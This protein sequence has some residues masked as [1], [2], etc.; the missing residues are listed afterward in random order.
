ME[1]Q[2]LTIG[3]HRQLSMSYRRGL[4][5]GAKA[6]HIMAVLVC[7]FF[8][9]ATCGPCSMNGM[10]KPVEFDACGSYRDGHNVGFQDVFVG[11][12][13]LRY[14][15]KNPL[16]HLSVENV[17][18]NLNL[19]CFPSTLP[20]F[21]FE[22]ES[23]ILEVNGVQ[24]DD[25]L[26]VGSSQAKNNISWSSD[27]G[28]FRQSS[29]R[30]LSCSLDSQEGIH[31]IS[32][33]QTHGP[34]PNDVSSCRGTL[35]N[36]KIP[37]FNLNEN[38]RRIK[39]GFL[40]GSLSPHVEITPHLLDWGQQ[41]LYFPLLAFLT[42][43]NTHSDNILNLYEPFSTD[44][45][46]Y[47]CNFSEVLLGPGEVAS[48][49]FVFLPT[50]LGL[51]SAHLILQT[52]SGG[53]LIQARGFGTESPY[54]IQ[55][56]VDPEV[57]SNGRWN[58]N[59]SLFNPFDETLY[60]EEVTAWI[61]VSLGGTSHLTKAIC[62][63]ENSQGPNQ[64]IL[65]SVK[66]WLDVKNG[67]IGTSQLAMKPHRNWEIGPHSTQ[68][69]MEIDFSYNSEGKIFGVLCMQLQKSSQDTVIVP[70]EAELEA[71]PAYGD[72]ASSVS[73]SI[74]VL[75][76]CDGS[77]T[78]VATL[79]LKNS[80]SYLLNV[81]KIIVDGESTKLFQIKYME[82]LI[83][84]P[85]TV[86]QVAVVTYAPLPEIPNTYLNCELIILT[87]DSS[88]PQFE[89]PCRDIVNICPRNQFDSYIGYD[90]HSERIEHGNARTRS[91]GSSVKSA[92]QI[93]A[94]ETAEAD[95]L[96][97]GN[98][99]SQGTASRMTVLDDLEVLF[100]T[101]Q[102]GTHHSKWITVK[103]PSQQPVVMQL[104]LN[105]G[106]IIDECKAS[107]GLLLPSSSSSL[108]LSESTTPTRYGFSI[109]DGALTE[110]IV[111]PNDRASFGPIFFHPS[112]RCGWRSSA[113]IRNN[114]SGVEW[115]SLRGFGGSQSLVLLDGTEPVQSLEF[116]FNLP[117]HLNFSPPEN[118]H[119][120]KEDT[121]YA[122]SRSLSK[123][124]Y[125]KNTGDLPLEVRR[126]EVSG[127]ECG[128]DGFVVHSCKGFALEP[129]QSMKLLISYQTDFTA[130]MVQRDLE[131]AL[132]TGILVIP[133]KAS[134]PVHMLNLCKKSV[135]WVQVKKSSFAILLAAPVMLMVFC[136]IIPQ[137]MALC[138]L[139]HLFKSGKSS[140]A[141]I[142]HEG[143]TYR[144]HHNQ[145][146]S[147]KFV[148]SSKMNGLLRSTGE[149]EALALES[150][151]RYPN[152]HGVVTEQEITAQHA[153]QSPGN[154]SQT[155]CLLSTR[156]EMVSSPSMLSKSVAVES[157][158]KQEASQSGNLTVRIGKEKRKR[159]R[160]KKSPATGLM[161][162][163][164]VSS[165]QS[166]NSTPSSPLSPVTSVIPKR[167]WP[168]SPDVDQS[169]ESRNLFTQSTKHHC[170]KV[171]E[172]ASEAI[173]SVPQVPGEYC[174]G[175]WFFP[176]QEK[177]SAPRKAGSKPVLLPSA[178]F[179]CSGRATSNLIC[180]SISASTSAI[181]AHARAPGS[182]L[183]EQKTE[184]K[185]GFEDQFKYD[186]WGDHLFG[187]N[188]ARRSKEASALTSSAT[189]NN[190]DSFFVRGPQ[191]F[192]TMFQP[193]LNGSNKEC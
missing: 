39:S 89:I 172:P 27:Y 110:A 46:F 61:S 58:K 104:I 127:T 2:T 169:V 90:H 32:S 51:S 75:V 30:T 126:I 97:L 151:I 125:A 173:M 73:V 100:P 38:S 63:I 36:Q 29:G 187:F 95:E 56:L 145:K 88:N 94:L 163:F 68:T 99:K 102:V 134:L 34:N 111:H 123:E 67:Q 170:E 18:S 137:M 91:L 48:I 43:A 71:K 188:S 82:G 24:S 5:H 122:C 83:L 96:V 146:S 35:L 183:Y 193:T 133:M 70:F 160:K 168:L 10:Q 152:G 64:R 184:E 141:T 92:S 26:S 69:I 124:L 178:T 174:N 112:N 129:G 107:D 62:S 161:G 22:E 8:G 109:A 101:V 148:V 66:E 80:A 65:P 132:T 28:M 42:V 59:L 3:A 177:P 116:K 47:P 41:Y 181:A 167:S 150:V 13:S 105:S 6:F 149:E 15:S 142:S 25:T 53:F 85:G 87:N 20:G 77:G 78:V 117:S 119:H 108:V 135:L 115:L 9:L 54:G 158:D 23:T 182:K 4:F 74:E 12:V 57:Y 171:S 17:C 121:T 191:T 40:D 81:V 79:S 86:T 143:K 156:K 31:D 153:N 33:L 11:D 72:L 179:P 76:P 1:S 52:S 157:S 166:G 180:P 139:D 50:R 162:H 159:Q 60:V 16:A 106:E 154:Q 147:N 7:T 113:L 189:E 140:I 49:C 186:I 192:K 176:T 185:T 130:V 190:S 19:F 55:P 138:S 84:F 165:S 144:V 128:L 98:W 14:V 155:N 45:Q 136:F 44:T 114:L 164:E 118:L 103:N 131:L 120:H 21:L 175:N 37:S 93:K